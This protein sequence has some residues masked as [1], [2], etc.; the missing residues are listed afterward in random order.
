MNIEYEFENAT[1][2]KTWNLV[3][4]LTIAATALGSIFW[5]YI[6]NKVYS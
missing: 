2:I 3:F 5:K 4:E 6:K 1:M